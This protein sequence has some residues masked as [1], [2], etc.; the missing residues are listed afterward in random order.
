ME[1]R[2][3]KRRVEERRV[4]RVETRV[5][6]TPLRRYL[7]FSA[8]IQNACYRDATRRVVN[9]VPTWYD[10]PTV[11]NSIGIAWQWR[12]VGRREKRE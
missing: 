2:G 10:L 12:D 4:A 7:L 3:E 8:S 5:R 11:H 9:H 1:R 6:I